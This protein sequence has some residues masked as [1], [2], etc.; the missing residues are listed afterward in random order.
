VGRLLALLT[1]IRLLRT[2]LLRAKAL[3]YFVIISVMNKKKIIQL[4]LFVT[5]ARKE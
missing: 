3:A 4:F 5:K 1:I 2:N